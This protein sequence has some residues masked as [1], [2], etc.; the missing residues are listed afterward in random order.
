MLKNGKFIK[1]QPVRI[2]AHYVPPKHKT[3]TE[4]DVFVYRVVMGERYRKPQELSVGAYLA[5]C[6]S[7]MAAI[8]LLANVIVG[9]LLE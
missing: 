8:V 9:L 6:F 4:E 2:G 5:M 7:G 3:P 1:E